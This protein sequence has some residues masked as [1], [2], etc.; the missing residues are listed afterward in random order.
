MK[1]TFDRSWVSDRLD[2]LLAAGAGADA[3]EAS[4]AGQEAGLMR[5]AESMITQTSQATEG[6]FYLRAIVG[7]AIG[8]ATTTDL[9]QAGL[10][11]C[12]ALAVER[13]R[14]AP[15]VDAAFVAPVGGPPRQ[16]DALD[17][18]TADVDAE[19]K[20]SW[21]AP[22]L[23]AHESDGLALAGR[24]HTGTRTSA[25]RST[26]GVDVF[27]QGSFSDISMSA[28][29]RPAGHRASSFR[30]RYVDRVGPELITRLADEVR[31]ECALARDPVDVEL[32]AW[33]VVLAPA[34]VAELLTWMNHIGFGS[35][36]VEDGL[37]FMSGR[38]G[39]QLTGERIDLA[40]DGAMPLGV[41]VPRPFDFEGHAKQRVTLFEG[42]VARGTVFDTRS[43]QRAG[44]QSTGHATDQA[45]LFADGSSA[46]HLQLAP[47]KSSLDDLLGMLD[48]GLYIT[49][50]H[51]VNGMLE[52]RRA[53]MTGLLR[54]AAFLVKGGRPQRAVNTMRFTD[55]ILE[56]FARIPEGGLGRDVEPH[57]GFG[58][59]GDCTVCPP[60]LIRGLR[61]TSGR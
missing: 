23:R 35:R 60:V 45:S 13:A 12:A 20:A 26:A 37:S 10:R 15:G 9:S 5:F 61:F 11:S 43:G 58:S 16:P 2:T 36:A 30:A 21:L 59:D 56:A 28:L 52:P 39:E 17:R 14:D 53:V 6:R 55:S 33:D 29:E 7:G 3:L 38:L 46:S 57:G 1:S 48:H 24:F 44:C 34:A 25:V 50:F 19:T 18:A 41:G 31:A 8:S 22:S 4:F 49:R 54:D 47:G 51:Y 42:G 40:D 32:G 27:H